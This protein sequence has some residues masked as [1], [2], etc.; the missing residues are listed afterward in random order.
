M[1]SLYYKEY[2]CH[3][4]STISLNKLLKN[5][6]LKG[7]HFSS[8]SRDWIQSRV[9]GTNFGIKHVLSITFITSQNT[10]KV[11]AIHLVFCFAAEALC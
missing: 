5:K 9:G 3:D 8:F 6:Q 7:A 10:T 4:V 11:I 1:N 2:K